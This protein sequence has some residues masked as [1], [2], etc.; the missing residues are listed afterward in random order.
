MVQQVC[1][2][3]DLDDAPEDFVPEFHGQSA[4][5]NYH[6]SG[7]CVPEISTVAHEQPLTKIVFM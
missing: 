6:F 2:G 4:D 7:K 5:V 3:D 1:Y